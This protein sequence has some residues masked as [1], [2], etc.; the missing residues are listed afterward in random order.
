MACTHALFSLFLLA[1]CENGGAGMEA[2]EAAVSN[3]NRPE[4]DV[5][6][7][8][9]RKPAEVL[10]FL[11]IKSGMTVLDVFAGGGYYTEILDSLVGEDGEVLSHNN[12][13]YLNFVGPQIE[14]RFADG[15]LAN[16]R[17][18]IAE[19]DALDLKDGSLDAV[20]MILAY[21][22]FFFG[23]EQ[24]GWPDADETL[25]IE[26]LCK[27]MKPG[28]IL[29]VVDHVDTSGGDVADVAAN[30]HRIDPQRV[31]SDMTAGCFELEAES[32]LLRN[33][34]DDFDKPAIAPELRGKTDRFVYKF[35]KR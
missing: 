15:R 32:D 19:A 33:P 14:E 1:P 3:P 16:S 10:A 13:S 31:I 11:G 5:Q 35:I 22:D 7:D 34:D 30:L 26:S 12:Q 25:F 2:I 18:L 28:A 20:V 23:N 4:A 8:A 29:G 6:R 21:H 27:A 9:D 24:Y 17:S